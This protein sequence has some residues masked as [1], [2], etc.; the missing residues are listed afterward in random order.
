M[1]GLVRLI[2]YKSRAV[3]VP[4]YIIVDE[5]QKNNFDAAQQGL[6]SR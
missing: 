6:N 4:Q 5:N 1:C 3:F 2:R